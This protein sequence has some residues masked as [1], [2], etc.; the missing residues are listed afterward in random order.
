MPDKRLLREQIH[1][2]TRLLAKQVVGEASKR[3]VS[4]VKI[5]QFN[6]EADNKLLELAD[7]QPY[8]QMFSGIIPTKFF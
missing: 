3:L 7:T 1:N 8:Y 4:G 6:E 5:V 2:I